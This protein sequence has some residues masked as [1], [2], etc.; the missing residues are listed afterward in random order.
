M[1]RVIGAATSIVL[2]RMASAASPLGGDHTLLEPLLAPPFGEP[3]RECVTASLSKEFAATPFHAAGSRVAKVLLGPDFAGLVEVLVRQTAA[4]PEAASMAM[5]IGGALAAVGVRNTLAASD[6]PQLE[7]I[8]ATLRAQ[9]GSIEEAVPAELRPF[10]IRSSGSARS[11]VSAARTIPSAEISA[12]IVLPAPLTAPS[13]TGAQSKNSRDAG[14][15]SQRLKGLKVAV[16]LASIAAL[17][18]GWP[19]FSKWMRVER[20]PTGLGP[21][22]VAPV[23]PASKSDLEQVA[24]EAAARAAREKAEADARRAAEL[25]EIAERRAR[26]AADRRAA[27]LTAAED[28]ERERVRKSAETLANE[29][30]AKA[31]RMA[32]MQAAMEAKQRAEADA[33]ARRR[34]DIERAE[35]A[36][37]EAAAREKAAR[38]L[39][40]QEATARAEAD[41]RARAAEAQ[42]QVTAANHDQAIVK[43]APGLADASQ[44]AR[45][46]IV[47]ACRAAL[48]ERIGDTRI[49]FRGATAT[50]TTE[51]RE[52]LARLAEAIKACPSARIRIDTYPTRA[53]ARAGMPDAVLGA[54]AKAVIDH[55]RRAGVAAESLE[56]TIQREV[57]GS[58]GGGLV[59]A[60]ASRQ[61]VE[62]HLADP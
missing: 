12:S 28:A 21:V 62:I 5:S 14:S 34:A 51:S 11:K 53:D 4:S 20:P 48:A 44:T 3:S 22:P 58:P 40:A 41:E 27:E 7:K 31:R 42:R 26:E 29:Q 17:W 9:T 2:A 35:A 37:R 57:A 56:A 47:L 16:A 8:V 54:R 13:T 60:Q 23:S 61:P 10:A 59:P 32:E 36:N 38:E 39:A 25:K 30:A 6:P 52:V 49:G 19:Q 33:D 1:V 15:S 18:V 43:S 50:M 55:L 45:K 24:R 46:A